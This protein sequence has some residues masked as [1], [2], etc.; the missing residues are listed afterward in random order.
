MDII[1]NYKTISNSPEYISIITGGLFGLATIMVAVFSLISNDVTKKISGFSLINLKRYN[2]LFLLSPIYLVFIT[3]FIMMF[4]QKCNN[5]IFLFFCTIII[6]LMITLQT[7]LVL[8]PLYNQN[9]CKQAMIKNKIKTFK[10]KIRKAKTNNDI[11]KMLEIEKTELFDLIAFDNENNKYILLNDKEKIYKSYI[12]ILKKNKQKLSDK[13]NVA[14][15]EIG[16]NIFGYDFINILSDFSFPETLLLEFFL[17]KN[18]DKFNIE[19]HKKNLELIHTLFEKHKNKE[20]REKIYIKEQISLFFSHTIKNKDAINL[21]WNYIYNTNNWN[22]AD[23]QF[24][25]Y[26]LHALSNSFSKIPA[27]YEESLDED[28]YKI[29]EEVMNHFQKREELDETNNEF[30]RRFNLIIKTLEEE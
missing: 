25:K 11:Q 4:Y 17:K 3:I 5:E 1:I 18:N 26:L 19:L 22:N 27:I 23:C 21:I 9:K 16:L 7:Y 29:F 2:I 30:N 20:S 12:D 24:I 14:L 8:Q 15:I 28:N 13:L 6:I 10:K